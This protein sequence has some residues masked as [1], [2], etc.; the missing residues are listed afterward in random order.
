LFITEGACCIEQN[1]A[2]TVLTKSRTR[3]E[4]CEPPKG[5]TGNHRRTPNPFVH[6]SHKLITPE[7]TAIRKAG[8]LGTASKAKQINGVDWMAAGQH[9]NVVSPMVRGRSKAMDQ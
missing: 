8:R 2:S 1:N 3:C 7:G 6:I 5:I 4:G 9:G